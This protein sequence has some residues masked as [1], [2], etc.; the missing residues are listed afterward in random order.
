MSSGCSQKSALPEALLHGVLLGQRAAVARA[1]TLVERED[2]ASVPLLRDLRK[3]VGRSHRVGITGPPGAGKSTLLSALARVLADQKQKVGVLAVDPTSPY[4]H[5]AVLGDRVRMADLDQSDHIFIRSMAS[6]GQGGGLSPRAA[7]AA[8]VLDAAGFNWLFVESVGVG[9]VELDI[10]HLVDSTLVMLVPESGDQVQAMKAGL[11]EIA[12]LYVVNKCDRDGANAMLA[13]V[14]S[15]V[16]LQHHPDS[17]WMP[18]VFGAAASTGHGIAEVLAE[19]ERHR[20]HLGGKNRLQQ[21]RRAGMTA[22]LKA[23]LERQLVSRLNASVQD[24]QLQEAVDRALAG[25]DSLEEIV[26]DW[27][28]RWLDQHGAMK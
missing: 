16:S 7:D 1:I 5:G 19:L 2:P 9:Q 17:D 3:H 14:Q 22:R 12:D 27:L 24:G 4:T 21:R 13:A 11:M 23:L 6:R 26:Q 8:D 28:S 18:R 25:T 20:A 10:R 15:C